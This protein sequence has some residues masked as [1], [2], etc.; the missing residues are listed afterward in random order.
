MIKQQVCYLRTWTYETMKIRS[1]KDLFNLSSLIVS[2]NNVIKHKPK[3]KSGCET[4]I[5]TECTL[6]YC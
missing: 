3:I 5:V 2:G 4:A 1:C 6:S